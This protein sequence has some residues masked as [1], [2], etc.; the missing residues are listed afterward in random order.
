[1]E[2]AL[3][4]NLGSWLSAQRQD[5]VRDGEVAG[6]IK[7]GVEI[8]LNFLNAPG[9][10]AL[11][12]IHGVFEMPR[13][14]GAAQFGTDKDKVRID[15]VHVEEGAGDIAPHVGTGFQHPVLHL[16]IATA[17]VTLLKGQGAG[18]GPESHQFGN[19]GLEVVEVGLQQP[20]ALAHFFRTATPPEGLAPAVLALGVAFLPCGELRSKHPE[21]HHGCPHDHVRCRVLFFGKV[22]A[23]GV[24]RKTALVGTSTEEGLGMVFVDT[25]QQTLGAIQ[26]GNAA[27]ALVGLREGGRQHGEQAASD[28]KERESS[29][30]DFR[31]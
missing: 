26:R 13:I 14:E 17:K 7:D 23:G 16:N 15:P 27:V 28:R 24:I 1:V 21:R 2:T 9:P 22:A 31:K 8:P 4:A 18:R 19:H 6:F 5:T 29:Q 20:V 3:L 11:P 12:D 30:H 10:L 25:L